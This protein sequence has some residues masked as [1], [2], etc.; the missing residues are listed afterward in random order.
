MEKIIKPARLATIIILLLLLV[1]IY[2]I[3]LYKLQIVE[4]KAYYEESVN[5]IVSEE[6]VPGS[7]GSLMDRYGRV[8]VENR[9]CNNLIL[10]TKELF[11]DEKPE[12]IAAAN[13]TILKLCQMVTEYGDTYS[14]TL[15]VTKAPPFEYTEMTDFQRTF[16][17]AYLAAKGLDKSTT[18]VELMAYMRQR[19]QIDNSYTAEEF[20]AIAGVR[21]EIN[22]RYEIATS[23]YIFAEDVSMELIT[24]LL[25]SD[26]GGFD[27]VQSYVRDYTTSYAAHILGYI[28]LMNGEEYEKYSEQ[29]YKLNAQVGKSGAE[30]AFEEYLHGSDGTARVTRTA[31]G[32][33]TSTVYTEEPKPG[34]HVYLTIDIGMQEAAENALNSFITTTNAE[35]QEHNDEIDL[36]GGQEENKKALITGGGVAVVEVKTG[37]PLA[38]ASWPTY[39]VSTL[40]DNFNEVLSAENSPLYN[41]ALQ[42]AYAPGSTFKPVVAIA[43]LAEGKTDLT[44]TIECLGKFSKYADAGYEPECW[45]YGK[46]LHGTLTVSQALTV[47]CNYYFYTLADYLQISLMAKYAKNFGLGESTGI[48]LDENLGQMSTDEYAQEHFGRDMYAGD[49]LAAGIGQAYSLFTPLQ[50]AEYCA[51]LANNGHRNSASIL[52]S[53]RSYDFSETLYQREVEE[54]S[55][56]ETEQ[57]YYDAVHEGMRGVVNDP[58]AGSVYNVFA[59]ASYS[60]AAKTGTAETGYENESYN[61]GFM[62]CY[63]PYDDPEI[64]I[65]VAVEH[66]EAGSNTAPIVRQILDYY[67]AFKDS[68]VALEAEGELLK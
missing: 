26:V 9:V 23:D 11:P 67:F 50:M 64:A 37:E 24:T 7:R 49:T 56:V 33:T 1:A 25:E 45:I 40:L 15:P 20:R 66:A 28:G 46:G 30:L 38:I 5:N 4:G 68:T 13:A 17:D 59:D 52:K 8:L 57:E 14:D 22:G 42:G 48:E 62:I 65:A 51:A 6:V 31:T 53:V 34:N 16:L 43:S 61:N 29:G 44:T 58:M 41:R 35:R 18:A 19:Y 27:V 10:N 21:Y 47:S 54:L 55:C 39:D 32:V 12:T 3:A 2:V 63:A 36:Y 60:A